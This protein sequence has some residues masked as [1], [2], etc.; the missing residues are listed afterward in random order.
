MPCCAATVAILLHLSISTAGCLIG[1]F[2]GV[3]RKLPLF[4]QKV[5]NFYSI[6]LIIALQ[7]KVGCEPAHSVAAARCKYSIS[8]FNADAAEIVAR[9]VPD[10]LSSSLGD[11]EERSE[12]GIAICRRR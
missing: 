1:S 2:V 9:L 11:P 12:R 4:W 6:A 7:A 5:R 8:A 10:S 3:L